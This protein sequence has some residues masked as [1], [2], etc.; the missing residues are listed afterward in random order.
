MGSIKSDLGTTVMSFYS[1]MP[2][3]LR[4]PV[5]VAAGGDEE[6]CQNAVT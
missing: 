6:S 3:I 2:G 4:A 1:H 5:S